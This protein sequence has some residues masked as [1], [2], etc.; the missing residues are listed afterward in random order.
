MTKKKKKLTRQE[1]IDQKM[2]HSDENKDQPGSDVDRIKFKA[3]KTTAVRITDLESYTEGYFHF[4]EDT[5]GV[6][7]RICCPGGDN[8]V[9]RKTSHERCPVCAEAQTDKGLRA[10][11]RYLFNAIQGEVAK[12]K[13]AGTTKTKTVITWDSTIKLL[14]VGP[15]IFNQM[16]A[17]QHDD[18]YPDI[19]KIHL[20]I[21]RIGE[22]KNNTE[23]NVIPSTKETSFPVKDLEGEEYDLDAMIEPM[24][25]SEIYEIMG[26]ENPEA[27]DDEDEDDDTEFEDKKKKKKTTKSKV[28][29]EELDDE[30][31]DDEEEDDEEEDDEEEDDDSLEDKLRAE[32]TEMSRNELKAYKKENELDFKVMKSDTEE[33]IINKIIETSGFGDDNL[34]DELEK[35]DD[36]EDE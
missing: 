2:A 1:I 11:H 20:K 28:E 6:L 27:E 9:E 18:E 4:V 33:A 12:K 15:M 16:L 32:L 13:V 30:E 10:G 17:I 25:L 24:A 7:R 26:L 22:G 21:N 36:D 23:Y 29:P 19:D 3:G 34:D 8:K 35:L 5:E 31:E 14:E